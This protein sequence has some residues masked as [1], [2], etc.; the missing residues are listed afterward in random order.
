LSSY[1]IREGRQ[2]EG[3]RFLVRLVGT[4]PSAEPNGSWSRGL[5]G[6]VRKFMQGRPISRRSAETIHQQLTQHRRM[7]DAQAISGRWRWCAGEGK[8]PHSRQTP[9]INRA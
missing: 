1:P 6:A 2:P 3:S 8:P 4:V 9:E 5:P 7:I